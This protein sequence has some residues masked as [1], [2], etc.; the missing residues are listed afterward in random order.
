MN[1][2]E[3]SNKISIEYKLP[4]LKN[5]ILEL[6]RNYIKKNPLN[7]ITYKIFSEEII[8]HESTIIQTLISN[9]VKDFVSVTTNIPKREGI[10][11]NKDDLTKGLFWGGIA[12]L[13]TNLSLPF[14]IAGGIWGL[15]YKIDEKITD[16]IVIE[17]NFR[18]KN[19]VESSYRLIEKYENE[20]LRTKLTKE[21]LEVFDL[22]KNRGINK[23]VHFT[24]KENLNNILKFGLLSIKQLREKNI[25]YRNLDNNRWEGEPDYI[26]LSVTKRN[27]AYF[28][29]HLNHN[30]IEIYMDAEL[31]WEILDT[32]GNL[33]KRIYSN[34]NAAYKYSLKGSS[35]SDFENMFANKV[36]NS[37]YN[38]TDRKTRIRDTSISSNETTDY[39]AEILFKEWI[40]IKY[41]SE[42][43]FNNKKDY[44]D[45][46]NE[47]KDKGIRIPSHISIKV[48]K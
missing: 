38:D 30:L 7:A 12:F 2:E 11:V 43:H 9:Y 1:F 42:I 36:E 21:Q 18:F 20:K 19:L 46:M 25:L 15:V 34:M 32:N 40:P 39:Q 27:R 35:I 33:K 17:I 14:L 10:Y 22:L 3:F 47:L 48:I 28:T 23:L 41:F 13:F 8:T 6:V 44:V 29:K 24:S 26:S 16:G 4:D 45:H 5:R 37:K 31:L